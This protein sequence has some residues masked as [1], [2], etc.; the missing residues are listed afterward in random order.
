MSGADAGSQIATALGTILSEAG[1]KSEQLAEILGEMDWQNLDDWD[2]L[3]GTLEEMGVVWTDQI[4]QFVEDAKEASN[5]IRK[6]D[7][8]TLSKNIGKAYGMLDTINQGNR[9]YEEDFYKDLIATNK[10]LEK[11]FIQ[12]GEKFVYL[13]TSMD[14]LREAI[15]ENTLNR[16]GEANEYK[17]NKVAMGKTIQSKS[18]EVSVGNMNYS[19][20]LD[21]LTGV[22]GAI[23]ESG[24]NIGDLGIEGLG[25]YT[26]FSQFDED[27]LRSWASSLYTIGA[28]VA[29][30]EKEANESQREVNIEYYTYENTASYNREQGQTYSEFTNQHQN[31]FLAQAIQSGGVAES[32]ISAYATKIKQYQGYIDE[33]KI[34]EAKALLESQEFKDL[35]NQIQEGIDRIVESNEN[36]DAYTDLINRT[37]DAIEQSRKEQIE[38][39]E[40]INDSFIEANEK[41]VS[42]IEEQINESRTNRDN[43]KTKA[44]IQDLRNQQAYLGMDTSGLN[45]LEILSLDSQIEDTEESFQD[46]LIDQAI[47]QLSD[48]NQTDQEQRQKQID[49]LNEQLEFEKQSGKLAQEAEEIVSDSL[50]EIIAGM[51]LEDSPLGKLLYSTEAK[52][53][54]DLAGDDWWSALTQSITNGINYKEGSDNKTNTSGNQGTSN[55]SDT[56]PGGI[57]VK[58]QTEKNLVKIGAE[59][60]KSKDSGGKQS[61][62]YKTAKTQYLAS[63]GGGPEAEQEWN[64]AIANTLDSTYVDKSNGEVYTGSF[65]GGGGYTVKGLGGVGDEQ[66]VR[67]IILF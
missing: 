32:L 46:A 33:G 4:A 7:F 31:A 5:A 24:K 6:I 19:Q 62:K 52:G 35:G 22:R 1:N 10:T 34:D 14:E 55:K 58:E 61:D 64:K 23:Q 18:S 13:G 9:E 27:T 45:N 36:R 49:I 50:E 47:Q 40:Q 48:A 16:I 57:S 67:I 53:L 29:S 59:A 15:K 28:N 26:D 51:P 38:S 63:K 2:N 66:Q 30:Y 54:N 20:L 56:A 60:I 8:S 25:A 42:K 41:L 39:L 3:R 44:N 21:W 12:I 11:S 43:E 17:Q 37:I 65:P